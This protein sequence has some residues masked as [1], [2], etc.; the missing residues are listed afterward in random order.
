MK[1]ISALLA[2]VAVLMLAACDTGSTLPEASGKATVRAINAMS[3]SPEFRFLIEE[4]TLDT[5]AYKFSTSP[6]RYD[7]LDYTFNIELFFTGESSVRRVAS[8][9]IDVQA[10]RDYTLLVSGAAANPTITVWEGDERI[11]D[12]GGTAFAARF[13][14]AAASL[15]RVDYYFSAP[16]VA[17]VLGEQVATLSFGEI[18]APVDYSAGDYVLTITSAGDPESV[19]YVSDSTSLGAG[20][21]LF[22]TP[23]DGI[24]TDTAPVVVRAIAAA[25]GGLTIPDPRFPSTVEFVNASIDLGT[26]DIYDDESLASPIVTAHAYRD[27]TEEIEIVAGSNL[28]FYTPAGGTG[29]VTLES[30]LPASGG[31]R[32][33]VVAA[34]L[35]GALQTLGVIPDRAGVETHAK[36]SSLHAANNFEFL[37]VYAVAPGESI[38]DA[39]VELSLVQLG[40][41]TASLT[42]GSYDLY[43]TEF[44]EKIV[45]AGPYRVDVSLGDV[46]DLIII[47]TEDPAVLD[48]L[49]LA[50]GP[51][52]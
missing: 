40:P 26:S 29:A 17:P 13:T 46:I 27:V 24:A 38:D 51:S 39:D 11:F 28:F 10:D 1:R 14:H 31:V 43:V 35:A 5:V 25:G 9:F 7:D 52:S 30:T 49:F 8:Q 19:L 2:A 12:E 33:R 37:D 47:D 16:G 45:L 32:Y 21:T 20:N 6:E 22:I 15:G 23:F 34:G 36:L 18:A 4:R 3:A 42:A 44:Q 48:V 41:A 50:G